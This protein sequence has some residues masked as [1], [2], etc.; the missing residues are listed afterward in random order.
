MTAA[1]VL[2][3]GGSSRFAGGPGPDGF[4][5]DRGSGGRGS[6]NQESGGRVSPS[7][8]LASFRGRPLASWAITAAM[9]SGIEEVVLV[10]G[11]IGP[12]LLLGPG[13][14]PR[15]AL[16][17]GRE[18]AARRQAPAG[19]EP[20]GGGTEI[21]VLANPRWRAGMATSLAV[22]LGYLEST[23]HEAAVVG[24]ADQ[25]LV[26]A[27]AWRLVAAAASPIAVGTYGGR[28]RNPVRLAR[29][30]WPLLPTSGDAGARVVMA[31]HPELVA[32]VACE[33]DPVDIDTEEDLA[34]WS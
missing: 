3:A 23:R 31:A 32:E 1:V 24:L 7:K 4:G 9:E 12:G 10:W 25:P 22:A 6:G 19:P 15:S 21:T 14:L 26:P 34:A 33:G 11:A 18:P 28:R 30:V 27:T 5:G 20:G 2:A 13:L 29:Q 16:L 8:L 17:L